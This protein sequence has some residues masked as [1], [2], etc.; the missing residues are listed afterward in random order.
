[1]EK[2]ILGHNDF[3][4]IL[5]KDWGNLRSSTP[6]K[7]CHEMVLDSKGRLILITDHAKNNIII[8][9]KS[10]R[11]LDT[12]GDQFPGGHGLTLFN[13]GGDLSLIHI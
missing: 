9:D 2:T 1:M 3:K 6:V 8:Y 13:E 4:Y 10:G 12:W 5:H 7:N 11:L